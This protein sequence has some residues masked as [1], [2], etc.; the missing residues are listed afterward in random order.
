MLVAGA[1][2]GNERSLRVLLK[3]GFVRADSLE[4]A[5]GGLHKRGGN[6][7]SE[8]EDVDSCES[9]LAANSHSDFTWVWFERPLVMEE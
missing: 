3:C 4:S 6:A 5:M 7:N 8:G 1:H 2:H 9:E